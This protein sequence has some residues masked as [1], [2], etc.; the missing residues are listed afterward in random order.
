MIA[1]LLVSII[2]VHAFWALQIAQRLQW[3]S[4]SPNCIP[5]MSTFPPLIP[6][7]DETVAFLYQQMN[8]LYERKCDQLHD[9][10]KRLGQSVPK[11]GN[12]GTKHH[13]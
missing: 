11:V 3:L 7:A 10:M 4:A 6:Q 5:V 8:A 2:D 13:F 12:G 9:A 1:K